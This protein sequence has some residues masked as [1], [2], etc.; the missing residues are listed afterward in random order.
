MYTIEPFATHHIAGVIDLWSRSGPGVTLQDW[1]TPELI[2]NAIATS[3]DLSFVATEQMQVIGAVVGGH[4]GLRGLI[5]HLAVDYLHR[6]RGIGERL[7]TE[8]CDAF[9][10]RGIRRVLLGAGTEESIGFYT[11]IGFVDD[12]SARLMWKDL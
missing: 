2:K 5:Q 4:F 3:P 7:M 9:K 8:C 10:Q 6:K 1:E 12:E 11:S